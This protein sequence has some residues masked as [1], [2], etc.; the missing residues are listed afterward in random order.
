MQFL[1]RLAGL[2][3]QDSETG[4]RDQHGGL[5]ERARRQFV[6][7]RPDPLGRNAW[8]GHGRSTR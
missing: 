6:S 4:D 5:A 8:F 1:S 3:L 2:D 7:L